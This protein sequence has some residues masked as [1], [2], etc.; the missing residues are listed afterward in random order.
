MR[1]NVEHPLIPDGIAYFGSDNRA[2]TFTMIYFDEREVSRIY[3]VTVGEGRV[4]WSRD[5]AELAQTMTLTL[6]P[7]GTILGQGRMSQNG[8]AWGDD[9]SLTY[10]PA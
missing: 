4:M 1:S 8:G 6:Q 10:S 9:L 3:N 5:D 7:D 2:D